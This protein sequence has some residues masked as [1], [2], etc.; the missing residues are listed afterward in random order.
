MTYESM[1]TLLVFPEQEFLHHDLREYGDIIG[2]PRTGPSVL[3]GEG[4]L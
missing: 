3:C 1:M 2:V 4:A